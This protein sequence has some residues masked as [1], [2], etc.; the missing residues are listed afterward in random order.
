MGFLW[1]LFA[2]GIDVFFE[3]LLIKAAK[4][5]K[6][7]WYESAIKWGQNVGRIFFPEHTAIWDEDKK[8]WINLDETDIGGITRNIGAVAAKDMLLDPEFLKLAK[9]DE[10]QARNTLIVALT[11]LKPEAVD[12]DEEVERITQ[13]IKDAIASIKKDN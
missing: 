10:N 4:T 11:W 3:L 1:T 2:K 6:V 12:T 5:D 7:E 8:D 13:E 9:L